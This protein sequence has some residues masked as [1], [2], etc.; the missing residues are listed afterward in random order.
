MKILFTAQGS[1]LDDQ[2]DSR[3]GRAAGFIVYDE[4][5]ELYE[6]HD[7]NENKSAGHGAGTSAAQNVAD[8]GVEAVVTYHVGDKAQ[9]ILDKMNIAVYSHVENMTVREALVKFQNN[10]LDKD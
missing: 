3:F 9:Q 2:M 6:W 10:E 5:T 4:A 7:N 8:L 1:K